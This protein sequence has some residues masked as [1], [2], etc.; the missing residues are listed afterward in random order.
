MTCNKVSHASIC[1]ILQHGSIQNQFVSAADHKIAR[2]LQST[3]EPA[4]L[5]FQ[6]DSEE[7]QKQGYWLWVWRQRRARQRWC[8]PSALYPTLWH[9]TSRPCLLSS[10]HALT[11]LIRCI[12]YWFLP[13]RSDNWSPL[14][15]SLSLHVHKA[16][17]AR[18]KILECKIFWSIL[19][20]FTIRKRVYLAHSLF[21]NN[22]ISSNEVYEAELRTQ[23]LFALISTLTGYTITHTWSTRWDR[24]SQ[25][26][27]EI[28][29][30]LFLPDQQRAPSN[31]S[32]LPLMHKEGAWHTEETSTLNG[33]QHHHWCMSTEHF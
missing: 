16:C 21:Q 4:I 3:A 33:E 20:L 18:A 1:H 19:W 25:R 6:D 10:S 14:V 11:V 24:V 32:C 15:P 26:F 9:R 23:S 5:E 30:Q 7:V 2:E 28:V 29:D 17:F 8:I 27:G 31:V 22:Y 12:Q 13:T